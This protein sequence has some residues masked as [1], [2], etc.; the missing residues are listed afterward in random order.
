MKY[1]IMILFS[2][3]ILGCTKKKLTKERTYKQFHKLIVNQ[4][5]LKIKIGSIPGVVGFGKTKIEV[6]EKNIKGKSISSYSYPI[7]KAYKN[8]D[9]LAISFELFSNNY[10]KKNIFIELEDKDFTSTILPINHCAPATNPR[11]RIY[12]NQLELNKTNYEVND[13]IFGKYLLKA[14]HVKSRR[15]VENIEDYYESEI[16]SDLEING[17]FQAIVKNDRFNVHVHNY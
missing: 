5:N 6:V 9:K 11:A 10:G 12:Q 3:I 13:T 1:W 2:F 14:I 16:I 4:E 17:I 15:Y 8:K 7:C